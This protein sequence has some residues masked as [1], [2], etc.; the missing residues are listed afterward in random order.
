MGWYPT[1]H[2]ISIA[3]GA[4][5]FRQF[6]KFKAEKSGGAIRFKCGGSVK[7]SSSDRFKNAG[8]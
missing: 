7:D 1:P 5:V 2:P 4:L 3:N 8:P 6:V